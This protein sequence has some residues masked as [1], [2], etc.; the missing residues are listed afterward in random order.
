M[1]DLPGPGSDLHWQAILNRLTTREVPMKDILKDGKSVVKSGL[2]GEMQA[3]P[4]GTLL[5]S[6]TVALAVLH[7]S[8]V[9]MTS[10]H[11]PC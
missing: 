10:L 7:N 2:H 9:V 8:T 11:T 4:G 3:L 1:W 5:T 6:S